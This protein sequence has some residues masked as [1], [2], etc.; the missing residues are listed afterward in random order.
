MYTA[1]FTNFLP[2]VIYIIYVRTL[3]FDVYTITRLH[4][5]TV[6]LI[7]VIVVIH[8]YAVSAYTP[9]RISHTGIVHVTRIRSQACPPLADG[10]EKNGFTYVYV[11]IIPVL[12]FRFSFYVFTRTADRFQFLSVITYYYY[13]CPPTTTFCFARTDKEMGVQIE[14]KQIV[15]LIVC[16]AAHRSDA[17]DDDDDDVR[18]IIMETYARNNTRIR[19]RRTYRLVLCVRTRRKE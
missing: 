17:P 6:G 11:N 8:P 12:F 16:T 19:A 15:V 3:I 1:H 9:I 10:H 14:R 5:D 4:F 18:I 7:V 2:S 13:S